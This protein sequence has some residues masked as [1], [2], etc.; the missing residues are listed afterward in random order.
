[1][2]CRK[3][4]GVAF[5]ATVVVVVPW[6]YIASFGP[7]RAAYVHRRVP[8]WTYGPM[9]I[10]YMPLIWALPRLPARVER[11]Y[12]EYVWKWCAWLGP[13]RP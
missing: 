6:F 2:T 10:A 1:M 9:R 3:K 11:Q 12:E 7:A 13:R 5:W 8:E 4:P